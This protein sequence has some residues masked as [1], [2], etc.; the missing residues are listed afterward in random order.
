MSGEIRGSEPA[1]FASVPPEGGEPGA[2][3]SFLR[4]VWVD[5][6]GDDRRLTLLCSNAGTTA[7]FEVL[8]GSRSI[9]AVGSLGGLPLRSTTF[10][11]SRIGEA[12]GVGNEIYG[13]RPLDGG[14]TPSR[15]PGRCEMQRVTWTNLVMGL[16]DPVEAGDW[17]GR[18]LN[19]EMQFVLEERD[20]ALITPR[21]DQ[22]P[23]EIHHFDGST[24]F[25]SI[26]REAGPPPFGFPMELFRDDQGRRY[27]RVGE[28]VYLHDAD[29]AR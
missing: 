28:R 13:P 3:H 29:R 16:D 8:P 19:G 12:L 4:G 2:G 5:P 20:G 25:A 21:G 26:P 6:V 15:S 22:D 24:V 18:Y 9:V 27:V 14:A 7:G 17:P 1:A 23:L 11:L 10:A